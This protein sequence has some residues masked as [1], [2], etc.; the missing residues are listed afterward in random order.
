ME[1]GR[2][3]KIKASVK[4]MSPCREVLQSVLSEPARVL[5]E[6]TALTR[7]FPASKLASQSL[8]VQVYWKDGGDS[9]ASLLLTA[10]E[11]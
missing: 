3:W 6:V 7:V 2:H 9:D 1:L 4:P 10:E 8:D 11:I 5:R